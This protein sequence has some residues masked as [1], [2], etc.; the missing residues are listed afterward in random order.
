MSDIVNNST[1]A[2]SEIW[3]SNELLEA[4]RAGVE[5]WRVVPDT[6]DRYEVS[7]L[8]RSRS[9]SVPGSTKRAKSPTILA[10]N[11]QT[12]GYR[13]LQICRPGKRRCA[14]LHVLICEAF[15]GPRPGHRLAWN[16]AHHDD[17]HDNNRLDNLKWCP[18]KRNVED[19]I[20]NGRTQSFR[21]K[22][23]VIAG[24]KH[25]ICT[26]CKAEKPETDFGELVGRRSVCGR[27]PACIECSRARDR[28]Y[29]RR[30]RATAA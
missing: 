30:R 19:K 26:L 24:I 6:D 10:C 8:G 20:R 2:D 27:L 9:W 4:T 13:S 28:E 1:L 3:A 21:R 18:H 7:N 16:A 5:L 15:I 25:Y 14:L 11:F 12:G 22:F 29:A 17:D 23:T